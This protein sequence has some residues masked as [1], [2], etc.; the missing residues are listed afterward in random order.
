MDTVQLQVQTGETKR[1]IFTPEPNNYV[2]LVNVIRKE[3]PKTRTIDFSLLYENDEGEYVVMNS[4]DPL[5]IR[6]A[7]ASAK[8]I[9][10]TDVRRLKIRI[11]EGSSPSVKVVEAAEKN[12]STATGGIACRATERPH[13]VQAKKR[14]RLENRL[15]IPS[16]PTLNDDEESETDSEDDIA[17]QVDT[18]SEKTPLERYV[19]KT[20]LQIKSKSDLIAS[21]K[22]KE[23]SIQTRIE[24]V[25]SDPSDGKICRNCHMRLG[26]TSRSCDFEKC[27]SVFKCGE[28]K[29]HVG[30]SN[31]KGLKISI[32]K[33]ESKL[34]K[35]RTELQNKK[36]A[37]ATNKDRI[38]HRIESDLFQSRKE[39]YFINGS[40]NW[41]LLRKHTY[42]VEKYCKDHMR[43]K[44]PAKQDV[45]EI[46][47]IALEENNPT[48]EYQR[49]KQRQSAQRKHGNPFK[50]HLERHGVHFPSPP[51]WHGE[52]CSSATETK[53]SRE[54]VSLIIFTAPSNANE[55]KEQ[56]A[57]VL[58]ERLLQTSRLMGELQQQRSSTSSTITT[59]QNLP[60]IPTV[61][62]DTHLPV[63]D[64]VMPVNV[65]NATT[66]SL[67]TS[68]GDEE[69]AATLLLNLRGLSHE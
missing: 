33:H 34:I 45:G 13:V 18:H 44:I 10:G 36:S 52:D 51:M 1:V 26:H 7:F 39:D 54:N 68:S 3:I 27:S 35:L 63:D 19:E 58:R 60:M 69:E 6:I 47:S 55:E 38:S 67:N 64:S 2:D 40:K 66:V 25:R 32:K 53:P 17:D 50:P 61:P 23:N 37:I 30:E 56:L 9:P 24:R 14:I 4:H 8:T 41:T 57:I 42:L 65:S 48:M 59:S 28:E 20:E 16:M 43:G 46:L 29:F 49:A 22:G 15:P 12:D 31:L 62:N 5:C 21:L 11:F